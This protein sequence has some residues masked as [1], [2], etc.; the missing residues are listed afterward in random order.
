LTG[1]E[2]FTG[3]AFGIEGSI[4]TTVAGVVFIGILLVILKRHKAI[5]QA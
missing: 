4:V 1:E 2:L 3:G 5:K